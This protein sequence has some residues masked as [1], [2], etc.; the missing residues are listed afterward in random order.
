MCSFRAFSSAP[1]GALGGGDGSAMHP[2]PPAGAKSVTVCEVSGISR[3]A[4]LDALRDLLGGEGITGA[5]V[6]DKYHTK[7]YNIYF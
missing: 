2:L 4:D 1:E 6:V 5:H 3:S 7:L